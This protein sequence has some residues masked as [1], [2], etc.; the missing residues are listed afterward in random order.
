[1]IR[2]DVMRLSERDS[3]I[4][5]GGLS[6]N[7]LPTEWLLLLLLRTTVGQSVTFACSAAVRGEGSSGGGLRGGVA[8]GKFVLCSADLGASNMFEFSSHVQ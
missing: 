5:V 6:S 4:S 2:H 7:W 1:M 8:A 3:P